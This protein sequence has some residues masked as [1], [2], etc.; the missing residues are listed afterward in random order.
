MT[1]ATEREMEIITPWASDG[2][3]FLVMKTPWYSEDTCWRLIALPISS[4]WLSLSGQYW[5]LFLRPP[6]WRSVSITITETLFS[7]II[8]QKFSKETGF[9]AMDA[10][11]SCL[12]FAKLIGEALM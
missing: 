12:M 1:K 2:A 4:S 3:T 8:C 6:S 9:G 5:S 11:N 7:M 10:M